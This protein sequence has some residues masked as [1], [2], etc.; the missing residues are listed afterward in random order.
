MTGTWI[1]AV[2]VVTCV[3]LTFPAVDLRAETIPPA[4][5][6]FA[7]L[8]QAETPDFQQHVVPLLGRLGCN[9]RSCHGSFQGRG[10]LRLSLIGYDFKM[11]H[12]SLTAKALSSDGER[13]DRRQPE[14]SLI[15]Q[16][17]LQR[18]D[19]EGGERF[20]EGS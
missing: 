15:L 10:D 20:A 16:K 1:K 18:V 6:R 13:L 12:K 11:D 17:P 9:G 4:N 8:V 19:H 2:G 14:N 7:A 5:E 3:F